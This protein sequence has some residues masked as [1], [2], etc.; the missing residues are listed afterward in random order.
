MYV[1]IRI[2]DK[3]RDCLKDF[4]SHSELVANTL[5]RT[6]K[7]SVKVA[8]EVKDFGV[9]KLLNNILTGS[10]DEYTQNVHFEILKM[11]LIKS[12]V[13]YKS[14]I[15]KNE[16]ISFSHDFFMNPSKLSDL[17]QRDVERL[18]LYYGLAD[19]DFDV[20]KTISGDMCLIH[21]FAQ[22]GSTNYLKL[23]IERGA[24]VNKIACEEGFTA[25][26]QAV[27][28]GDCDMVRFLLNAGA[29]PTL[30]DYFAFHMA[31]IHCREMIF[32]LLLDAPNVH[33]TI[34]FNHL[35][36]KERAEAI[37]S[38][39]GKVPDRCLLKYDM[40]FESYRRGFHCDYEKLAPLVDFCLCNQPYLFFQD[41]TEATRK[42]DWQAVKLMLRLLG[43]HE[44]VTNNDELWTA[45]DL[46]KAN[47]ETPEVE[48]ILR[49]L[50]PQEKIK[51]YLILPY[52]FGMA[53]ELGITTALQQ[54]TFS[55]NYVASLW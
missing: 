40:Q 6:L 50:G 4:C 17:N 20:N 38:Q 48:L 33:F 21:L 8:R 51:N 36:F 28:F 34:V 11:F 26:T 55:R 41:I 7:E 3:Y 42:N 25:L 45:F 24:D 49:S 29:D 22:F 10:A 54:F 9:L 18:Y 43:R 12:D 27:R 44:K 37:F 35:K 46:A 1:T 19:P 47:G 31:F 39:S 30:L 13:Y 14:I 15:F 23:L 16:H 2:M 5:E 53:L 52:V 32:D